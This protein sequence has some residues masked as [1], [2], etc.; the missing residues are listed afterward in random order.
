MATTKKIRLVRSPKKA[1]PVA[2][3][4]L[5]RAEPGRPSD[6]AMRMA[7]ALLQALPSGEL[8]SK[9]SLITAALRILHL[10]ELA[11]QVTSMLHSYLT[12]D[13]I[14]EPY[15]DRELRLL[16]L[17]LLHQKLTQRRFELSPHQ[18]PT[19]EDGVSENWQRS[20]YTLY[21]MSV[22]LASEIS[23]TISQQTPIARALDVEV[24]AFANRA[25]TSLL[26]GAQ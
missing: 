13:C 8:L 14:A 9:A 10:D 22:L 7:A 4:I 11:G 5:T 2:V 3:E 17:D 18:A 24:R 6:T 1:K 20:V 25:S 23:F 12:S 16:N 15:K 21:G 19:P 26:Y